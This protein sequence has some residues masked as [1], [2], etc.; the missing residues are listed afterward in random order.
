MNVATSSGPTIRRGKSEQVVATP[1][2]FIRAVEARFGDISWD[3]AASLD[4]SKAHYAGLFL[5][6]ETDSLKSEWH[7]LA[8]AIQ[9]QR[10]LLW[11]NPPFGNIT[12]WVTKCAVEKE[13]GAEILLLVPRSGANWYWNWVEP[14]AD[15]DDVGR[16]KFEGHTDPYP[17]DLILAHYHKGSPSRKEQRWRW[18]Q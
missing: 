15:V 7:K 9:G 10:N 5:S 8:P 14:Y 4:N 13:Q 2:E 17:K 16:M 1:W 12:P 11:L 6:E 3:L 18:Q